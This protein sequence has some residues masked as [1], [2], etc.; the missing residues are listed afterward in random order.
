MKVIMFALSGGHDNNTNTYHNTT[1][2][3]CMK[4]GSWEEVGIW[5]IIHIISEKF[6][7][8]RSVNGVC[9]RHRVLILFL[10]PFNSYLMN[11]DILQKPKSLSM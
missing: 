9:T 2:K 8:K 7:L 10:T 4:K 1:E 3:F 6:S 11:S 5:E